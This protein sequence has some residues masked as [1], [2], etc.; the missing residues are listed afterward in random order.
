MIKFLYTNAFDTASL[1]ASTTETD[2][3]VSSLQN[4]F[5]AKTWKTT[6]STLQYLKIDLG[7]AKTITDFTFFNNNFTSSAVVTL[8]GHA[9]DLGNALTDWAGA[10]Y[11]QVITNF[12]E[13][14]GH[15]ALSQTLRYWYFHVTYPLHPNGFFSLGRIVMGQSIS[16]DENFNEEF[17]ESMVDPSEQEWGQGG[18]PFS[19]ERP[20]HTVLSF[21]FRN[22]NEANQLI[23]RNLWKAVYKTEPFVVILDEASEPV[24]L[25]RYGVLQSDMVFDWT[26]NGRATIPM[27]FREI[28]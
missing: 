7:S 17:Q 13:R 15:I 6:N 14:S 20:R 23:L 18:H 1:T 9:S 8:C 16:T 2:F 21:T 11:N 12:D 28:R 27:I 22:L 4:R 3:P 19:T 24:N 26:F 5:L 10:T 25:T